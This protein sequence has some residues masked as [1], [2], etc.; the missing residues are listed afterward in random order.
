MIVTVPEGA[1][2]G[3]VAQVS[4]PMMAVLHHV[5]DGHPGAS[6]VVGQHGVR[7]EESRWP[8][9]EHD[10]RPRLAF[11]EE[12]AVVVA[13]RHD[14]EAIDAARGKGRYQLPFAGLILLE[15]AGE[16]EHPAF[17]GDV[18]DGPVQRRGKGVADV[19]EDETDGGT[20]AVGPPQAARPQVVA[21]V[22]ALNR[23]ANPG[24]QFGRYPRLGVDDPRHGL[25]ADARQGGDLTHGGTRLSPMG[26]P[27]D[28]QR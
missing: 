9:D 18:L 21:V 5:A 19:L 27:G 10:R 17:D 16:D 14:H 13:G 24:G 4:D 3:E 23:R 28:C 7:V 12:V 1:T 6:Q 8:V 26:V 11:V 22:Q 20:L 2:A 25:D 15:A